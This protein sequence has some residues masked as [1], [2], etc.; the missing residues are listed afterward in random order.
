MV[1]ARVHLGDRDALV[2]H[3]AEE[4][5]A[6][7]REVLLLHV[8]EGDVLAAR[9][10]EQL[11]VVGVDAAQRGQRAGQERDRAIGGELRTLD[12][13]AVEF[14]EDA[15]LVGDLGHGGRRGVLVALGRG[16]MPKPPWDRHDRLRP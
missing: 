7:A 3:A 13:D 9:G 10:D 1:G 4:G 5:L 15:L 8:A 11:E 6:E 2:V 14:E 12:E 16:A